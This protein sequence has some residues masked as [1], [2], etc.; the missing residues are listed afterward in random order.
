VVLQKYEL[1]AKLKRVFISALVRS[2]EKDLKFRRKNKM[3]DIAGSIL[4]AI[5]IIGFFLLAARVISGPN[6]YLNTGHYHEYTTRT[7]TVRVSS[8]EI[9]EYGCDDD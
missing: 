1:E 5:I 4:L 7:K 3:S 6:A 8:D 9:R 2:A